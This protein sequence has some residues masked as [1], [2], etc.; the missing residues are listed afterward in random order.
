MKVEVQTVPVISI[1]RPKPVV[2][3]PI[4]ADEI[5]TNKEITSQLIKIVN[6]D[7]TKT[8][9]DVSRVTSITKTERASLDVYTIKTVDVNNSPIS[10]EIIQNPITRTVKVE[11]DKVD[12][13]QQ[14]LT[15]TTVQEFTGKSEVL[16]TNVATIKESKEF[17][18]ITDYITK[19][20][21]DEAVLIT[22][23]VIENTEKY[24]RATI[25][26]ISF[27]QEETTIQGTYLIDQRSNTTI[28][29]TYSVTKTP[30]KAPTAL[31]IAPPV[32][33][34]TTTDAINR[35]IS[36][37]IAIINTLTVIQKVDFSLADLKPT[38]IEI[39]NYTN[40]ATITLVFDTP[41]SNSR[42]L[43]FYNS[44]T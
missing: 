30:L 18:K 29:L 11:V 20:H 9:L 6:T 23:P 4:S 25:K 13:T 41:T 3:L 24:Q 32:L 35:I 27:S 37:N 7:T 34:I 40:V 36:N 44:A 26:T 33:T 5:L 2:A 1:L 28:E 19:N 21:P 39:R 38:F 43:V 42:I 14:T 15:Q 12:V 16:T 10:V 31:P 8:T 22:A 17:K